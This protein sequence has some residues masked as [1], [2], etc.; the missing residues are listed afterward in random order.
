MAVLA[1]A[2]GSTGC[3]AD[4]AYGP[5]PV[6][7]EGYTPQYYEGAVVYYDD[8]GRPFV[9]NNGVQIWIPESSPYYAG[10]VNYYRS[11]GPAYRRWYSGYGYRYRGYYRGGGRGYRGGGYYRGGY[12]APA[13][14][15][16]R[17]R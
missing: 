2:F 15:Y 4:A 13:R 3:Y 14:G 11:Y 12:R 8:Y 5:E 9:Y 16:Y 17:R 10:Y 7:A 6:V 1:G